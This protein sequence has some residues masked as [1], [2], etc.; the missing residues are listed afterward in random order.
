M[1]EFDDF[2]DLD[3]L[4]GSDS[5]L[6]QEKRKNKPVTELGRGFL[7]GIREIAKDTATNADF[8]KSTLKESGLKEYGDMIG[9][10][11]KTAKEVS[12]LYNE[13]V[14]VLKD[15]VAELVRNMDKRIPASQTFLK[16]LSERAKHA[17]GIE[18]APDTSY[19]SEEQL[20]EENVQNTVSDTF[21]EQDQ[22]TAQIA[23]N[24][25][26]KTTVEQRGLGNRILQ[27]INNGIYGLNAFNSKI[28]ISYQKKSLELQV[29]SYLTHRETLALHQ[30]ALATIIDQNRALIWNSSLPDIQ[31]I[32][33]SKEQHE[34]QHKMGKF[35]LTKGASII[36]NS[37]IGKRIKDAARAKLIEHLNNVRGGIDG[38]NAGMG[39]SDMM[40]MADMSTTKLTGMAAASFLFDNGIFSA[41]DLAKG[42]FSK[43]LKKRINPN[44]A[45]AG[46]GKKYGKYA[47][48]HE[49]GLS[50]GIK[51]AADWLR[52][53]MDERLNGGATKTWFKST[54]ADILDNASIGKVDL[55][56][57][58]KDNARSLHQ[59]A[60]YNLGTQKSIT[61]I[62]PGYLAR[63]LREVQTIRTGKNA[64]LTVFDHDR[65]Q[66][67]SASRHTSMVTSTIKKSMSGKWTN[68]Q[69]DK[70]VGSTFGA[71]VSPAAAAEI[72]KMIVRGSLR[73]ELIDGEYLASD[74]AQRHIPTELRDEV[75]KAIHS[76]LT[77][78]DE[79]TNSFVSNVS[80]IKDQIGDP[81]GYIEDL[82]NAGYHDELIQ[83]KVI[84]HDGQG[85]YRINEKK[86]N[87][88]LTGS[89]R[90]TRFTAKRSPVAQPAAVL[91]TAVKTQKARPATITTAPSA[92]STYTQHD[93]ITSVASA[94]YEVSTP[95]EVERAHIDANKEARKRVVGGKA[96]QL[97]SEYMA[98]AKAHGLKIPAGVSLSNAGIERL[99]TAAKAKGVDLHA[100]VS[101]RLTDVGQAVQNNAVVQSVA[102]TM[103]QKADAIRW[104]YGRFSNEYRDHLAAN[105]TGKAG[106]TMAQKADALRW[107]FGKNSKEYMA[108]VAANG[109]G[110]AGPTM[111][112]KADAVRWT[113]GRFSNEYRDHLA[114]N[115][116]GKAGPTPQQKA[117]ALQWTFGK[118]S[119][120]YLAHVA[121]MTQ[122]GTAIAQKAGT[123]GRAAAASSRDYVGRV[124]AGIQD[125]A[126]DVKTR[127][128]ATTDRAKA[129]YAKW[130]ANR[131]Q[132]PTAADDA[133]HATLLKS[134]DPLDVIV[135]L[136]QEHNKDFKNYADSIV[137]VHVVSNLE[138][139]DLERKSK[140]VRKRQTWFGKL[141]DTVLHPF[142]A[143]KSTIHDGWDAIKNSPKKAL[144]ALKSF[145]PTNMLLK[146]LEV[147]FNFATSIFKGMGFVKDK[148]TKIAGHLHIPA[149]MK[150]LIKGTGKLLFNTPL[151]KN[152]KQED[153][154]I[155]NSSGKGIQP[156]PILTKIGF[157]RGEYFTD[158]GKPCK[159]ICDIKGDI[160]DRDRNLL[161]SATEL[162]NGIYDKNG[163]RIIHRSL[164][165][166]IVGFGPRV[167]MNTARRFKNQLV[168]TA[169]MVGKAAMFAPKALYHVAKFGSSVTKGL[170][171]GAIAT[172]RGMGSVASRGIGA[173]GHALSPF[174]FTAA[175]ETATYSKKSYGVLLAILNAIKGLKHTPTT[176]GNIWKHH[177]PDAVSGVEGGL[178]SEV[179]DP[180]AQI[181]A[182]KWW[183]HPKKAIAAKYAGHKGM[184]GIKSLLAKILKKEKSSSSG[185][186][187]ND[188]EHAGEFLGGG[189][190]LKKMK[191]LLGLGEKES[192]HG[193]L[194]KKVGS[195]FAKGFGK[196][197][198]M[199]GG[200]LGS[201]KNALL[202]KG[203][204]I[205]NAGKNLIKSKFGNVAEDAGAD[206]T[207]AGGA[208]AAEVG[209]GEAGTLATGAA[210]PAAGVALAGGAGYLAGKYVFNPLLNKT[211]KA[212]TGGKD[213]SLGGLAYRL[214]HHVTNP[215]L[216]H[217]A[218]LD[219]STNAPIGIKQN[220]P[221]YLKSWGKF[222]IR[223]GIVH[224]TQPEIGIVSLAVACRI[225]AGQGYNNIVSLIK[226][227]SPPGYWKHPKNFINSISEQARI[228]PSETLDLTN[229]VTLDKI[230]TAIII[231]EN[232]KMYY[233]PEMVQ[234]ASKE[235]AG[236]AKPVFPVGTAMQKLVKPDSSPKNLLAKPKKKHKPSSI[237]DTA[238]HYAKSAASWIGSESKSIYH[239]VSSA[240]S[241]AYA[242]ASTA[243]IKAYKGVKYVAGE[244]KHYA[245]EGFKAAKG[246]FARVVQLVGIYGISG[247]TA[248]LESRGDA[249]AVS[250][251]AGDHGG[252]SYGTFQLSSLTS[253]VQGFLGYI[254]NTK[255]GKM[256][257][258]A[259]AVDSEPFK[260]MWRKLGKT[261]K[262]FAELQAQYN[263]VHY[264]DPIMKHLAAAGLDFSSYGLGVK[265]MLDRTANQFGYTGG[266]SIVTAALH[267]K[268]ITKM[269]EADVITTIENHKLHNIGTFFRSSSSAIQAGVARE[270]AM[271]KD[272]ALK[273]NKGT[274]KN[275]SKKSPI[276]AKKAGPSP[277]G[278][279]PVKK[280]GKTAAKTAAKPPV[281][282]GKK[283]ALHVV[284]GKAV[285]GKP[286][287]TAPHPAHT[288]LATTGHKTTPL[289]LV[290]PTAAVD[291]KTLVT[292]K[293]SITP[294]GFT[295]PH[296]T[297]PRAHPIPVVSANH[298]D[299]K[300]IHGHVK[301]IR[302]TLEKSLDVQ[303]KTYEALISLLKKN[304]ATGNAGASNTSADSPDGNKPTPRNT[305]VVRS[306]PTPV[307]ATAVTI[308]RKTL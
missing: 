203:K 104:T 80:K 262:H 279:V 7:S 2:S 205:L 284:G 69:L 260:S 3:K 239:S 99:V 30:R 124:A 189:F 29:R 136:L 286:G 261:D 226:K 86:L 13:S 197:G 215:H 33:T 259:G 152:C 112:Q 54:L 299:I 11:A 70:V 130:S 98:A 182:G 142:K 45:V 298:E 117:D 214:T 88:F 228:K 37:A 177:V 267:G 137:D 36:G 245:I 196:L 25:R 125:T 264:F 164:L 84:R 230:I 158:E 160:Y 74:K 32:K 263:I 247:L 224:F 185:G 153:I 65:N 257:L 201:A 120:E 72:K 127:F 258:K 96:K 44:G 272:F 237:L 56:L 90:R 141:K 95:A 8:Y 283:P 60:V 202:G 78:N 172:I 68:E 26:F 15:P 173:M 295:G 41:Q 233:S 170:A 93:P 248:Y 108:H 220:N 51:K 134:K 52:P 186:V 219:K 251:G 180:N 149:A 59:A 94:A 162:K 240:A 66:F 157:S 58:K 292:P 91:R 191:G 133:T 81:R 229:P 194:L 131:Q 273:L 123:V 266:A 304:G 167:A 14:R 156:N 241:S 209:V 129:K 150:K 17:L 132:K 223:N 43:F 287:A 210:L 212:V 57:P 303:N 296:V 49:G 218:T 290:K 165:N 288:A 151:F 211:V 249:G 166:K 169:K 213:K 268:D 61:T 16:K 87:D 121:T 190:L 71:D 270:I 255:E 76:K 64:E 234:S 184:G 82:I 154:Y 187:L 107:T 155:L 20:Q 256:L 77:G 300:Q 254:S 171:K 118:N 236:I 38:V 85:G 111:A 79:A 302:T 306:R 281:T 128:N 147:P 110:K 246:A 28:A 62:I 278:V 22:I 207:E 115:G 24:A 31:K 271:E 163:K 235:V 53:S 200:V 175:A 301:S 75:N 243:A 225:Y 231:V 138:Y 27:S 12:S 277:K 6:D 67:L 83:G 114:A 42:I 63:I 269:S 145:L 253:G 221:G 34:T 183:R 100:A 18:D 116:T 188:L 227:L 109:T 101:K 308:K 294:V 232:G 274:L 40:D 282:A 126:A 103:A 50:R 21:S 47:I 168:S 139:K 291:N 192:L 204:S 193:G 48:D 217:Y 9:A 293:A 208:G 23:E 19:K 176:K 242:G 73:R 39:M 140:H 135:G 289:K 1:S 146:L 113:Y 195:M 238:E 92:P 244:A 119:K 122:N 179:S 4:F 216:K 198:S 148:V 222:K 159:G 276:G 297:A 143:A 106:P 102:P 46:F 305:P 97:A 206:A 199:L 10:A 5:G 178:T 285:P 105:G 144:E 161:L 280:G 174:H 35:A 250:S 181:Y 275:K 89:S 265:A 55:S 307:P 252:V